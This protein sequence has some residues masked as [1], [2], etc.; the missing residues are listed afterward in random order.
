MPNP[1]FQFLIVAAVSWLYVPRAWKRKPGCR[2]IMLV[3]VFG[4]SFQFFLRAPLYRL[5]SAWRAEQEAPETLTDAD[6]AP[7]TLTDADFN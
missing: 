7:D 5:I 4:Y 3:L 1:L 2:R 6:F